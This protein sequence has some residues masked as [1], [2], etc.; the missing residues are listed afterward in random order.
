MRAMKEALKQVSIL[1]ERFQENIEAYQNPAYNETQLRIEFFNK[2]CNVQIVNL[3]QEI[4]GLHKRLKT[5]KTTRD[6]TIL[7]R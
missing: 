5:G 7:Q 6:K 4:L 2:S 3:V 1:V